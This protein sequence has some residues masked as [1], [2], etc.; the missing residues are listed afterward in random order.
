MRRA[1][2]V[3]LSLVVCAGAAT[4]AAF[5]G[6]SGGPGGVTTLTTQDPTTYQL[7]SDAGGAATVL[8]TTEKFVGPESQADDV[9]RVRQ[10]NPRGSWSAPVQV[11]GVTETNEAQLVESSSGAAAV[12]W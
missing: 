8:W 4:A 9:I 1:V 3:L 10:Q 6:T 2:V 5:A 11:G 12:V 7:A